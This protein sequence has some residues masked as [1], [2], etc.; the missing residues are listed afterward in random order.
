MSI[1]TYVKKEVVD[2]LNRDHFCGTYV[3][4]MEP[5]Y[6]EVTEEE[7]YD[8]MERGEPIDQVYI[9]GEEQKR[10]W[11]WGPSLDH[12]IQFEVMEDGSLFT[13]NRVDA[14]QFS[15]FLIMQYGMQFYRDHVSHDNDCYWDPSSSTWVRNDVSGYTETVTDDVYEDDYDYDDDDDVDRY[16]SDGRHIE[17]Y[18]GDEK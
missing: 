15:E 18:E 3:L 10:Y 17:G 16:G 9:T 8:A 5:I 11:M 13:A 2:V 12:C 4:R 1:Y 7:W 14:I 6:A